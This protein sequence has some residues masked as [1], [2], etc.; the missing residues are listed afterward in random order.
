MRVAAAFL[1]DAAGDAPSLTRGLAAEA[2]AEGAELLVLPQRLFGDEGNAEPSDGQLARTL[3]GVA[4]D[5]G[6]ALACGYVEGAADDRHDATLLIGADGICL[7]NYRRVHLRQGEAGRFQPGHWLTI[8]PLAGRR[9]GLMLGYDLLFPEHG[10][11]LA[12]AGADLLL[13]QARALPGAAALGVARA[14]ENEMPVALSGMGQGGSAMIVAADGSILAE[15]GGERRIA[16][17]EIGPP[18]RPT[19]FPDRRI[20]LYAKLLE[21]D[22]S[23]R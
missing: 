20:R 14:L 6:L 19:R 17:A 1:P 3:V 23:A 9:L 15:A 10:R 12:L 4:R 22:G 18:S 5:H 16:C 7:A 21:A 13:V 2:A 8:M 11:A